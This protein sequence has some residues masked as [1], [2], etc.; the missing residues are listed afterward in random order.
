MRYWVVWDTGSWRPGT[1]WLVTAEPRAEI[2]IE[3][4]GPFATWYGA[5]QELAWLR[6]RAIAV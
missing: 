1:G 5:E 4:Y 2:G 6:L 3:V